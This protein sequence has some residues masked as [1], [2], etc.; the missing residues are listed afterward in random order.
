VAESK[1][2]ILNLA[3]S[4]LGVGKSVANIDTEQ[5]TEADT[6]SQFY[7]L[8]R[9][10]VLR[11][12]NWPFARQEMIALSLV[13]T[14]DDSE[15]WKYS[16]RYPSNCLKLIRILSGI[17]NDN[18]QSRT[19][20]KI[21]QDDVGKVIYTDAES[22]EVEYL[23]D[24]EVVTIFPSDFVLCLSYRLAMFMAPLITA[25]DPFQLGARARENYT[26]ELSVAAK[27]SSN[28]EQPDEEVESEFQRGRV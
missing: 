19:P 22:A 7:D 18:R 26:I 25:G 9:Q 28:E 17:R 4:H 1:T 20:Y 14:F 15:E 16:Y 6:G 13:E 11:D 24:Q 27:N 12:I 8:A 2:E 5:S 10:T 23:V 3:L 21:L